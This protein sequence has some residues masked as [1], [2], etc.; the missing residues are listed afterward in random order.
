MTPLLAAIL[1]GLVVDQNGA[2]ITNATVQYL[3]G[4][5]VQTDNTG[6]YTTPNL[7]AGIYGLRI[8]SPGFFIGRIGPMPL[9]AEDVKELPP[10]TL[11]VGFKT[12]VFYCGMKF[13]APRYTR[14]PAPEA[15]LRGK[16]SAPATITLTG[17][18][19]PLTIE[20]EGSFHFDGLA[21]G[22]YTLRATSPDYPTFEI[23]TLK[24]PAK[25]AVEIDGWIDPPETR[26]TLQP[27]KAT[28]IC[29]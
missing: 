29:L 16:I 2:Y 4:R 6:R 14:T 26:K 15:S 27:S 28:A 24:I 25:T 10:I 20:A 11:R 23:R 21:P 22:T 13:A 3:P 1:T 19:R 18:A 12:S 8:S 7:P 5:T 9:A 17:G